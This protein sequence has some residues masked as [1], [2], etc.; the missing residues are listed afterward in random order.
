MAEKV[1]IIP[2]KKEILE[3]HGIYNPPSVL[4]QWKSNG[5]FPQIF[6]KIGGRVHIDLDEFNKII[7]EAK[8]ERDE[9]VARFK[10]NEEILL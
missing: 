1:N 3:K 6:L 4:R 2:L 7:E 5:K 10:K 8:R 9:R